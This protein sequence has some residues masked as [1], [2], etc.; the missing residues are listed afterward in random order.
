LQLSF[1]ALA[2]AAYDR[3]AEALMSGPGVY[4]KSFRAS[5]Q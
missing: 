4:R 5:R 2:P 3:T 1:E